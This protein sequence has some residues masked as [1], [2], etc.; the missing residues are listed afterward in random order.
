[1][2][3]SFRKVVSGRSASAWR[4]A[5]RSAAE[6]AATPARRSPDR[7]GVAAASSAFRSAKTYRVP[8][9][10]LLNTA[11]SSEQRRGLLQRDKETDGERNAYRQP[12]KHANG[13]E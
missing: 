9:S 12:R 5:T 1:M 6:A 8:P 11:T 2:T 13:A 4:A 3:R 7:S 10:A